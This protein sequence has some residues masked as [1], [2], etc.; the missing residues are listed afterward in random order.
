[1]FV[2]DEAFALRK[3]LLKPFSQKLLTNDCRVF[4]YHLSQAW[5]VRENTFGILVSRFRVFHTEINLKFERIETVVF[6]TTT[7]AKKSVSERFPSSTSYDDT[8]QTSVL[9]IAHTLHLTFRFETAQ[10]RPRI[11]TC[12]I[13]DYYVDQKGACVAGFRRIR[14]MV[15]H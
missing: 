4:N 15:V 1:M 12:L 9:L 3:D 5:R 13:C 2:G 14:G 10:A 6:Y 11:T 8:G 7:R